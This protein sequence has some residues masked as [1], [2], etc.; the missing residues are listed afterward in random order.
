MKILKHWGVHE[1]FGFIITPLSV[2]FGILQTHSILFTPW[3]RGCSYE[4]QDTPN[5]GACVHKR[6]QSSQ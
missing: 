1:T 3:E 5:S 2:K 6:S 4:Q